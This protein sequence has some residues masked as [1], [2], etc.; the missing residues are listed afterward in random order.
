MKKEEEYRMEVW[1]AAIAA[2][3][4]GF[5]AYMQH[6]FIPVVILMAVMLV[7]YVTG[8]AAAWRRGELC[9]AEGKAGIVRKVANMALVAVGMVVDYIVRLGIVEVG[10]GIEMEGRYLFGLLVI[11]WLVLNELISITENCAELG[12]RVPDYLKKALRI[13]QSSTEP[14]LPDIDIE[15][16]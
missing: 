2:A 10:I 4:A 8:V 9:S 5:S 3:V 12:V 16:E 14:Q 11:V 15:E 6:L 1:K 13:A 7:D